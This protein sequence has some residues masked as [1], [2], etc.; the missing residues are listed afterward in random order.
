MGSTDQPVDLWLW[1]ASREAG[2]AEPSLQTAYPHMAVDQYPFGELKEFLTARA[3][4]NPQA[5]PSKDLSAGSLHAKGF[6]TATM[7][8]RTSQVVRAAGRWANGQWTVVLRRP[9]SVEPETGLLL[10]AGDKLSVA[11]A[12]WDGA[13]YDRNGQKLVSIWHNLELE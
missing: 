1:R 2:S 12:L 9:L 8:P 3:A 6:G 11:F 10:A 7:R 4:G 5:D 13:A